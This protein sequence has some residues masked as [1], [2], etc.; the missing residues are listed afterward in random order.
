MIFGKDRGLA[1]VPPTLGTVCDNLATL[2]KRT[3]RPLDGSMT[4]QNLSIAESNPEL[5]IREDDIC[6]FQACEARKRTAWD[7]SVADAA[8]NPT[9]HSAT[10]SP[11]S[12]APC[13]VRRIYGCPSMTGTSY[14][15]PPH[16]CEDSPT[17]SA[18][19]HEMRKVE[20]RSGTGLSTR[21]KKLPV[22]CVNDT[23]LGTFCLG[24]IPGFS[25]N[26][27]RIRRPCESFGR[28]RWRPN[29]CHQ[30]VASRRCTRS[31]SLQQYRVCL[32]RLPRRCRYL[33]RKHCRL[34]AG[35]YAADRAGRGHAGVGTRFDA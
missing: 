15:S 29:G 9:R 4:V 19:P 33:P 28:S 30:S 14:K 12:A 11:P 27:E 7:F 1:T 21:S 35:D 6:W 26:P 20:L 34:G 17:S 10:L 8:P 13:G 5:L 3:R 22:S 31:T 18:T 25:T 2:S 16:F 24:Y 23:L 32:R